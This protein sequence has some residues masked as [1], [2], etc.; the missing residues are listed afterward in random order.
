M[1]TNRSQVYLADL[2]RTCAHEAGHAVVALFLTAHTVSVRIY[3]TARTN[4]VH[5]KLVTGSCRFTPAK[6]KPA[7]LAAVGVAGLVAEHPELS[8]ADLMDLIMDEHAA[9]SPSDRLLLA[10]KMT[11]AS[12]RRALR[13]AQAVLAR[14]ARELDALS[15][16]LRGRALASPDGWAWVELRRAPRGRITEDAA[17]VARPSVAESTPQ[18][19]HL[20]PIS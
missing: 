20:R 16:T 11:P 14:H 7:D 2:R 18:K 12:L 9:L 1:R 10:G 19:F 6:T 15:S 3:P 4:A 17:P 8:P 13:R 5:D